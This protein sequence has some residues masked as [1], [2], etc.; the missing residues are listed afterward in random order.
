[1]VRRLVT[2]LR[3]GRKFVSTGGEADVIGAISVTSVMWA[4]RTLL[5]LNINPQE[6]HRHSAGTVP[7]VATLQEASVTLTTTVTK[8]T[9]TTSTR[10]PGTTTG[11]TR[12]PGST[13][14]STRA[15]DKT[16][17]SSTWAPSTTGAEGRA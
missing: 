6:V 17:D 7:H 15:E 13:K 5:D 16:T 3:R 8:G 11:S 10:A 2:L 4:V 14:G 1:M 9:I 12:A